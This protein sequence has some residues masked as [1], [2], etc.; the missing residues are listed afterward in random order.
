MSYPYDLQLHS[1]YS[2]GDESPRVLAARAKS[3]GLL[4][5]VLT[6]HN[7]TLGYKEFRE[8]CN[9]LELATVAGLEITTRYHGLE[10]HMLGYARE[11]NEQLLAHELVGTIDGYN[12]RSSEIIDRCRLAGLGSL[13]FDELLAARPHGTYV[14]KYDIV[15]ALE[16]S[17][18]RAR[19]ELSKLLNAG[20]S[21]HVPYGNWALSPAAAV[22]IIHHAGGYAVLAHP[23]EASQRSTVDATS[24]LTLLNR[25]MAELVDA[26]LDGLEVRHTKHSAADEINF[27]EFANKYD[28]FT[29]GGSDWHGP[30]HHPHRQL[31][32]SGLTESEWEEFLDRIKRTG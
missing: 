21:L 28:L 15:R 5:V 16:L 30:L 3:L 14:T 23:G 1:N 18:G 8:S 29:T 24:S 17:T 12:Q 4:G 32:G 25:L 13:K 11:F 19:A 9:E 10:I 20:G 22:E 31:G 27:R 7:T 26:H 6:D 2:D